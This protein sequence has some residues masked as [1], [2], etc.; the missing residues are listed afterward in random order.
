M[1]LR[2]L[3]QLLVRLEA[4][5]DDDAGEGFREEPLQALPALPLRQASH[6]EDLRLPYQNDPFVEVVLHESG[7]CECRTM[8]IGGR[9]EDLA[10]Q[11]FTQGLELELIFRIVVELLY[12]IVI[13]HRILQKSPAV[14]RFTLRSISP[15][16]ADRPCVD[17]WRIPPRPF[18][19]AASG[20]PPSRTARI[21]TGRSTAVR[22]VDISLWLRLRRNDRRRAC[23]RDSV[24]LFRDR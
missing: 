18:A 6:V 10:L 19:A 20:D 12:R 14:R 5:R 4:F 21:Q 7:Q 16:S 24:Y 22:W 17:S 8:N 15:S 1:L 11:A 23:R 3:Q 9:D 2:Q 13:S